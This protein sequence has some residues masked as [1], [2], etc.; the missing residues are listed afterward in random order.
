MLAMADNGNNRRGLGGGGD[1]QGGPGMPRPKFSPWLSIPILLL[2]LIVF[3][4]MLSSAGTAT[5]D[6]SR[7]TQLVEDGADHRHP[8][9][10]ELRHLGDV[11]RRT[12][13]S[14]LHHPARRRTS[15]WTSTF[16]DF[17]EANG[18]QYKFTQ[19][20]VLTSLLINILPFVLVMLLVYFFIFRR[21]GGGAAGRR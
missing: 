6:Y 13:R 3:N 12:A 11:R 20:S 15:S 4:N 21:M 18:V 1:G 19:P 2:I 5:I 9:D 10:L 17:L 14:V 16:T 7:F 8:H